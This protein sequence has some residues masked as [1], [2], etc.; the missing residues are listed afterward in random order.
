MAIQQ[1]ESDMKLADSARKGVIK[2]LEVQGIS[3]YRASL[4]GGFNQNQVSRYI[5]G[6]Q[7]M[8]LA[9]YERLCEKGLGLPVGV[10]LEMGRA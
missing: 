7:D 5:R 4:D 6:D 10:V 9:N 1:L 3:P 8:T 2:A